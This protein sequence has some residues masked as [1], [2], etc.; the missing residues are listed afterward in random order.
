MTA[1]KNAIISW[2]L[3][4]R[5]HMLLIGAII[6]YNKVSQVPRGA[7]GGGGCGGGGGGGGSMSIPGFN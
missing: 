2:V 3:N 1:G 7:V 6:S 4:F 5:I